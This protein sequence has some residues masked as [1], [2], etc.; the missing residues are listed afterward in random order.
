MRD[1]FRR[2]ER[3]E[4]RPD[5]G[6]GRMS[7]TADR[8]L[9][10]LDDPSHPRHLL[11]PLTELELADEQVALAAEDEHKTCFCPDAHP[12]PPHPREEGVTDL[13]GERSV[14]I[15]RDT[16]KVSDDLDLLSEDPGTGF[17]VGLNT[18]PIEEV[19]DIR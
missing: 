19:M 17:D 14:D 4:L 7:S 1:L 3:D 2:R 11:S 9:R 5:R 12:K 13:T 8:E 15:M 10:E 18:D 16:G 6:R